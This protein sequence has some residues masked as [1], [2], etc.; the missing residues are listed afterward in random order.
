[1]IHLAGAVKRSFLFPSDLNTALNYY[2]DMG[3]LF[4]YLPHITLKKTYSKMQFRVLY[5]SIELGIY[6]IRLF[7]DLEVRPDR[8]NA[9]IE[10]GVLDGKKPIK[11]KAGMHSIQAMARYKSVSHFKPEGD[12]VR[13]YYHLDLAGELPKPLAFSLVPD[14]ITD[15][16]AE[17]IAK[18]RIFE[19][20]D[21][22]ITGSLVD[23]RKKQNYAR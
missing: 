18:R 2:A 17:G 3:H 11:N 1:M 14:S 21:G 13:I 22:F 5:S 15:Y 10:V 8:E 20:A 6:Q 12:C 7:C 4:K 23:F 9:T 16:I 19:I